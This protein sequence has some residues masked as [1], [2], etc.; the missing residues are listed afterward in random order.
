MKMNNKAIN[1]KSKEA[2]DKEED[3]N[4]AMTIIVVLSD[5]YK[6]SNII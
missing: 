5:P 3:I 1:S 6:Y 2:V 4:W